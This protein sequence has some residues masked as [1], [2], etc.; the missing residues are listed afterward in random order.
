MSRLVSISLRALALAAV[1]GSPTLARE[2]VTLPSGLKYEVLV[3]GEEGGKPKMFDLVRV[4][5]VGTLASDGMQFDSSRDRGEPAEFRLGQVIEGWN[6]GLQLMTK[7]ARFKFTIPSDLAYGAAGRPPKIPGGATLV[8]DIELLDFVPSPPLP[9]FARV[10]GEDPPKTSEG[11]IYEIV[12]PGEGDITESDL[13]EFHST[14][15]DMNGKALNSTVAEGKPA[16]GK[17]EQMRAPFLRELLPMV[18]VGGAFRLEVP[19]KLVFGPRLPVGVAAE[20]PTIWLVEI[21]SKL[22]FK[23]PEFVLPSDE[24]LATTASGLKYQVVKEG[25]GVPPT[26]SSE[27]KVHYAGW[28]TDGTPFDSSYERGEPAEFPL[29]GVIR[30]WTEGLQLMKPG[31]LYRFVIPADLAYGAAGRPSIPPHATLV[32][33]VE[34][35]EVK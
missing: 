31:A 6:E 1:F 9:E 8:F 24:Q 27:V 4:H 19:S 12:A 32:F 15:W 16:K 35:L 17:A 10:G 22:D 28:L 3:E 30:G 26:A 25:E 13:I 2:E 29:S 7:G 21:V 23:V 34:L 14:I 20:D 5:Y 18:G 11:L 33:Q